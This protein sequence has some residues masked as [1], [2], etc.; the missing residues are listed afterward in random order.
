MSTFRWTKMILVGAA[1]LVVAGVVAFVLL[2]TELGSSLLHR[3]QAMEPAEAPEPEPA[4]KLIWIDGRPG[5]LLTARVAKALD[6]TPQTIYDVTAPK[7]LRALPPQMGTLAY[8]SDRLFAV[9][10]NFPGT[11]T[12]LPPGQGTP[13]GP[14]GSVLE[15]GGRVQGRLLRGPAHRRKRPQPG[16]RRRADPAHVEG[17]S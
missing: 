16:Q 12:D 15:Q 17:G 6:I 7:N 2:G 14:G 1:L 10:T 4:A 8:D 13:E 9:R 11:V 5:L 3:I